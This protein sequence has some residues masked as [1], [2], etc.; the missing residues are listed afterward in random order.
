MTDE[1]LVKIINKYEAV[2][3]MGA[4]DAGEYLLR[5]TP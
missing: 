4:G 5:F 1:E 3:I 2:V